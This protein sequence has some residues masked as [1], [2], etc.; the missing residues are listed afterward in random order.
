MDNME[1][2][3][4]KGLNYI[5]GIAGIVLAMLAL[6]FGGYLLIPLF[7]RVGGLLV[8]AII[9]LIAL[10]L[11]ALSSTR[12][13]EVFPMA[14]PP[15]R[16]LAGS[17]MM[18]IGVTMFSTSLSLFVGR[19]FDATKRSDALDSILLP[20]G[21]VLALIIGAVLPAVCE[22]FFCRGFLVRCFSKIKNEWVLI[23]IIGAVFGV[24]HLDVYTFIPTAFMGALLCLIAL[25]T[26]SLLIPMLLHFAN[27]ALAVVLTFM[28]SKEA[29]AE[30]ADIFAMTVPQTIGM[31]VLYIGLGIFPF[32]VGYAVFSGRRFFT[33][34]TFVALMVAIGVT[35]VGFFTF[36]IFSLRFV[37]TKTERIT[38][39]NEKVE[40][41]LVMEEEGSYQ[42]GIELKASKPVRMTVIC[43]ETTVYT[44]TVSGQVSINETVEHKGGKC[45]IIFEPLEGDKAQKSTVD[46][47]YVILENVIPT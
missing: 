29:A 7:G 32:L 42:L 4:R 5:Y 12:L 20:M 39:D 41:V 37:E 14:L 34:K 44:N 13:R 46:I 33:F 6:E 43:G 1:N 26:K 10:G 22:E 11:T 25:R 8:G 47:T 16:Q 27:N 2:T 30:G 38:V 17:V 40:L 23:A 21:P 15:I 31:S 9:A 35:V 19:F 45:L 24:M 36:T 28:G 3:E 18:Y